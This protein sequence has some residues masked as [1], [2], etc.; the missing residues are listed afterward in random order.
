MEALILHNWQVR[1]T[2]RQKER[3]ERRRREE[4]EKEER[5]RRESIERGDRDRR[6]ERDER[7]RALDRED[8]E[9][10]SMLMFKL[11]GNDLRQKALK[12]EIK[13]V[14]DSEAESQ[15]LPVKLKLSSLSSLKNYA[16]ALVFVCK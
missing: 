11:L 15:P 6:D 10:M 4:V 9:R 16:T 3:E 5:D 8:K 13:V 1:E 12:K 14:A 2:D 7:I